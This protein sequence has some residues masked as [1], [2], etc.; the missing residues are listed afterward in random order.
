MNSASWPTL[1]ET[2]WYSRGM[3]QNVRGEALILDRV[4]METLLERDKALHVFLERRRLAF[5]SIAVK[6]IEELG[7]QNKF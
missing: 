3:G 7:K 5:N 6:N 2:S 4:N 1:L